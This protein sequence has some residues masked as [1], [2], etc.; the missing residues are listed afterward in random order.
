MGSSVEVAVAVLARRLG[1]DDP[2][3]R[4]ARAAAGQAFEEVGAAADGGPVEV[5]LSI[6]R[7]EVEAVL[8][9]GGAERRVSAAK[10]PPDPR[11]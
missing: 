7:H 9:A 10:A 11:R 5:V 4:T 8:Q 2:A 1:L 3:V 6:G